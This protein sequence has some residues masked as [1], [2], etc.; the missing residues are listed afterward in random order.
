MAIED[1]RLHPLFAGPDGLLNFVL[2]AY[3]KTHPDKAALVAEMDRM[4]TAGQAG[5]DQCGPLPRHVVDGAQ[6]LR[7]AIA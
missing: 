1:T 2:V 6:W 4:L 5:S 7:N 3:A